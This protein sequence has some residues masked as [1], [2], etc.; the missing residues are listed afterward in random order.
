MSAASTGTGTTRAENSSSLKE[1][2]RREV[3]Y[4]RRVLRAGVKY[5]WH[6]TRFCLA[7]CLRLLPVSRRYRAAIAFSRLLTPFTKRM[8]AR[9]PIAYATD[10][11][12]E[13]AASM[14]LGALFAAGVN[15]ETQFDVEG[16]EN[17]TKP[18]R[19][20][21]G[22]LLIAA[23]AGLNH[24]SLEVLM[25]A[26]VVPVVVADGPVPRNGKGEYY[27]NIPR[28]PSFMV[29]VRS[30]LK[31]GA[32]VAAAVNRDEP[33]EGRTL[34]VPTN[35]GVMQ[36]TTSLVQVAVKC[37]SAIVFSM[38][39]LAPSGRIDVRLI[40]PVAGAEGDAT[41]IV[42]NFGELVAQAIAAQTASHGR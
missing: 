5:A 16:L 35:I 31:R 11:P 9:N 14:V 23:R 40:A 2:A 27:A 34:A 3:W 18:Y 8:M 30:R 41:R 38:I 6:F 24:A 28:T 12:Y 25:G 13:V 39:T 32:L 20:G 19:E 7:L 36:F 42:Q 1:R 33:L 17:V 15:V 10:T 26:Q 29:K 22:V 21:R 4:T 37:G